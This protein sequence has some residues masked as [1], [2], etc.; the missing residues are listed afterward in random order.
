[1]DAARVSHTVD[2]AARL[3]PVLP[4]TDNIGCG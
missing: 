4:V 3:R 2:Y 1:M